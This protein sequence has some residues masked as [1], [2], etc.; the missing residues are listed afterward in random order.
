M[1]IVLCT[2]LWSL[3]LLLQA[4]HEPKMLRFARIQKPAW[5]QRVGGGRFVLPLV[6]L[7]LCFAERASTAIPV[8]VATF[9]IAGLLVALGWA[10]L[11][12]YREF[13]ITAADVRAAGLGKK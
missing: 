9:S 4:C 11:A 10:G 1:T 5:L 6:A 3:F 8:W 2:F 13:L 7:V 12:R